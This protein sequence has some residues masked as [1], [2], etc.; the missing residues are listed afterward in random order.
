MSGFSAM[1]DRLLGEPTTE[2][3]SAAMAPGESELERR[4]RELADQV[5]ELHW[6]LGGLAYEMAIRDHFRL[7]VLIARA[8]QL[9]QR[10][11]ELAEIER[12]LHAQSTGTAG[13]C[14]HCGAVRSRGAVFCWQC[15]WQLMTVS[16]PAASPDDE[17]QTTAPIDQ[18][19]H[20]VAEPRT[21]EHHQPGLSRDRV[22]AGT[23]RLA[24]QLPAGL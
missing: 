6:D 5:A 15:G 11:A 13:S 12:L 10:D 7:D 17:H 1:R 22:S 24:E 19:P 23:E 2:H 8:A 14:E 3:M 16:T 18:Q 9:Q 20:S 4:R 21:H